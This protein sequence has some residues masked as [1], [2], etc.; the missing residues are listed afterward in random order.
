MFVFY[1]GARNIFVKSSDNLVSDTVNAY[2][3]SLQFSPEWAN[4]VK[5]AVFKAGSQTIDVLVGDDCQ[6]KIPWEVLQKPKTDL[7]FGVYGV[8]TDEEEKV[9]L[10][11]AYCDIGTIKEGASEGDEPQEATLSVYQQ[12]LVKVG[13]LSDKITEFES[14]INDLNS[15]LGNLSELETSVNSDIVSAINSM[16]SKE[17]NG[18]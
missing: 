4:L 15:K 5:H 12:L 13:E 1:V 10:R 17:E 18:E 14:K 2:S 6:C 9:I 16:I 11:T 3:V 8:T 7:Y